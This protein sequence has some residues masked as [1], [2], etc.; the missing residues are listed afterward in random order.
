MRDKPAFAVL[1]QAR[2]VAF[3]EAHCAANGF[4]LD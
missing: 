1:I 2:A 3:Y 4:Q